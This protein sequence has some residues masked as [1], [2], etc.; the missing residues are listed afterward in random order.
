[1]PGPDL[2]L[3]LVLL[4][5]PEAIALQRVSIIRVALVLSTILLTGYTI[6]P[7]RPEVAPSCRLARGV[8]L[9]QFFLFGAPGF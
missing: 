5:L 1:M 7:S 9:I 3:A 4:H 6:S 8:Q 2:V